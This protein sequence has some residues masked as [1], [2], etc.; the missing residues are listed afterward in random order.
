MRIGEG[1][2]ISLGRRSWSNPFTLVLLLCLA[3][4]AVPAPV[5]AADSMEQPDIK[6]LV[7]ASVI[8]FE[9][10]PVPI[11]G[12][13]LVPVRPLFE[14][15][16]LT[17]DW[18]AAKRQ[19]TVMKEGLVIMLRI[20]DRQAVVNG[21]SSALNQAP[22]VIDGSTMVPLRFIGEAT[23]A[24]VHWDA[25]FREI[26]IIT[27]ELLNKLGIT[28][29]QMLE[30][31]A[32]YTSNQLPQQP[33]EIP[34][35]STPVD[36]QALE[37]MYYGLRDDFG[38]YECGGICWDLYTF[39]PGKLIY[40]GAP[41]EGGPETIDCSRDGCSTYS[42]SMGM[43]TLDN[44]KSYPI[45]KTELGQLMIDDIVL[46]PVK[47]VAAGTT[48]DAA[49]KYIGYNGFVGIDPYSSSWTESMTFHADGTF[50]RDSSTLA[51]LHLEG[52]STTNSAGAE[53][54]S[55]KYGI[56]GNTITL[57]YN[58]GTVTKLLFFLHEEG[59]LDD[60]QLGVDNYEADDEE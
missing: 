58:D 49:Y 2:R 18:N 51:S 34:V 4:T 16:G 28:K 38:G 27:P 8:A 5:N 19:V 12:T 7:D 11:D 23:G 17:V 46:A 25:T 40:V 32:A 52:S 41:P 29:E 15:M 3:W 9:V 43:L 10:E 45:G 21:R 57:S 53:S 60:I 30:L 20:D 24:I 42:I 39:L 56:E 47:R 26:S 55:G 33:E 50:E 13:T 22:K 14:A 6:V 48:L 36:L 35:P 59:S 31:L 44:G 37:G 1:G 54:Q